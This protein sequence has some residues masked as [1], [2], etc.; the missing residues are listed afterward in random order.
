[1]IISKTPLRV[2]FLGGGTDYPDYF[3]RYGEGAVLGMTIDKHIYVTVSKFYS[4]L[5]DYSI[6]LSYSKIECV[7]SVNQIMHSPFREC[8]RFLGIKKDIEVDLAAELPAYSGLGSSSSFVVGLLNALHAF[9]GKSITKSDLA[10]QAIHVEQ[11][12][13]KEPVGCQDQTLAA[14]GG[15][16]LIRFRDVDKIDVKPVHL[17]ERR[18]HEFEDHLMLF[19]TGVRRKASE[20]T[21]SQIEKVDQNKENLLQMRKLVDD[22]YDSLLHD[23][24]FAELGKLLD[25]SWHLKRNLDKKISNRYLDRIY[26]DG[27]KGG[28]MGGKLLGAG[29]GGFFL[30]LVE[31]KKR[32]SV[33]KRLC[34]LT[35]IPIKVG[36]KG[37][38]ILNSE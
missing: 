22:G 10:M 11:R 34:Y 27:R 7:K 33:R 37:S 38:H 15:F 16:N 26:Q 12:L 35:E 36:R 14:F 25:I 9:K 23:S 30:F 3:T 6:R 31:P 29:G 28:A 5:F 8:L 18:L 19:F 13:L 17:S 4:S 20:I 24:G 21:N 32:Q 1:M 2:S